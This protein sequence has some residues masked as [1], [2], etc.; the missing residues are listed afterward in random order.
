MQYMFV[1]FVMPPR[2]QSVGHIIFVLSVILSET[3]TLLINVEDLILHMGFPIDKTF[4]VVP[5]VMTLCP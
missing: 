5:K 4:P 2:S 3:L 1:C